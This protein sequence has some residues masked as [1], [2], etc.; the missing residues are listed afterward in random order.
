MTAD[1]LRAKSLPELRAEIERLRREQFTLRVQQAGG[2]LGQTH[3]VR[4]ARRNVARV[5]TIMTEKS[6]NG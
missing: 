4:E 2:Q 3:L 6:R 5:K 1:E